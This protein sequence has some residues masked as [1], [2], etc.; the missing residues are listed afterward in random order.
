MHSAHMA[1]WLHGYNN[2]GVWRVL[3]QSQPQVESR[4]HMR[5]SNRENDGSGVNGV[6]KNPGYISPW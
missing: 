6:G 1:G 2:K 3:D 4:R 5:P